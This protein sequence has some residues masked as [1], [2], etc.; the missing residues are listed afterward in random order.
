[1]VHEGI[2]F[3]QSVT[4]ATV[5][6]VDR[7]AQHVDANGLGTGQVLPLPVHHSHGDVVGPAE[8]V[9]Q[10]PGFTLL[11]LAPGNA[12]TTVAILTV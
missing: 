5:G 11:G 7:W 1:M 10:G 3:V 12:D 8:H 6:A 9:G 4:A 2:D